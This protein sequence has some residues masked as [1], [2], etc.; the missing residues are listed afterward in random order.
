M[1][2][3][4]FSPVTTGLHSERPSY[5]VQWTRL[6]NFQARRGRLITRAGSAEMEAQPLFTVEGAIPLVITEVLNPRSG[7]T[8]GRTLQLHQIRRPSAEGFCTT[9]FVP[10]GDADLALVL[11]DDPPDDGAT[12]ARIAVTAG[13][14]GEFYLDR[15][16]FDADFLAIDQIIVRTR[17]RFT[18]SSYVGPATVQMGLGVCDSSSGQVTNRI[19]VV[20]SQVGWTEL[21][22]VLPSRAAISLGGARPDIDWLGSTSPWTIA[23][24]NTGVIANRPQFFFR[25]EFPAGVT[26]LGNFEVDY[27]VMG[28]Y[29][30][31]TTTV[32]DDGLIGIDRIYVT[33][34][35]FERLVDE[36]SD[37]GFENVRG[38][39]ALPTGAEFDATQLYG[40]LYLANGAD[41]LY[42]YPTAGGIFEQFAGKPFGKTVLGFDGRVHLGWVTDGGTDTPERVRFS[43]KGDGSD[44]TG[45]GSGFYD[46]LAA[47]G[48]VIKLEALTE[49]TYALYKQ[50]SVWLVRRT[51]DDSA[52]YIP[53]VIDPQT[54]LLALRT[55]KTAITPQ[56]TPIQL[57]LG[58]NPIDGIS[59]FR[60]DGS[61]VVDVGQGLTQFLRDN[62]NQEQI[63]Y[64]FAAI[65]P[66]SGT[67]WLF[68]PEGSRLFPEKAW[69]MD[70][71]TGEWFEGT[72]PQAYSAAGS[73]QLKTVTTPRPRGK[74][75]LIGGRV[76]DGRPRTFVYS[77]AEDSGQADHGGGNLA[78]FTNAPHV[79]ETGDLRLTEPQLQTIPYSIHLQFV[80]RG[81]F[82]V[83]VD[84]SIDGGLTFNTSI[85][86]TF[87]GGASGSLQYAKLDGTVIQGRRIRFRL[88]FIAV[89][90]A[91]LPIIEI[92]EGWIYFETGGDDA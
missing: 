75:T 42:R 3:F 27:L 87:G 69:I 8:A 12:L 23:V 26:G 86:Q 19:Q 40:Q 85:S 57:F 81:Q 68:V 52:P 35:S 71:R 11:D 39:V 25:V 59:V 63:Q 83:A 38:A 30:W 31:K 51:G 66:D 43:I 9:G 64:S 44:F 15:T 32:A 55:V 37:S 70:I 72:F 5:Q 10:V 79:L 89:G 58:S 33:S 50:Q 41:Q 53:D 1:P 76:S 4:D 74:A 90:S 82:N 73:W 20:P 60:F 36:S 78:Q 54:G 47:P 56:G 24:L 18:N 92:H 91:A 16:D 65:D 84:V 67:Y 45:I 13:G 6:Q 48:G 2:Y 34:H 62:A 21:T 80:D 28:L 29:G 77:Q 7:I 49:D 61:T 88:T 46:A 22:A 17:V 14:F